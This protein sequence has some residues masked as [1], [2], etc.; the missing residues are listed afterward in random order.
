MIR[1]LLLGMA[2]IEGAT[3]WHRLNAR[4]DQYAKAMD[5]ARA[6]GRPLVV[7]GV[8]TRLTPAHGYGDVC[9][10][11]VRGDECLI[12][13]R[14]DLTKGPIASIASDSVVVFCACVLEYV[15]DPYAVWAELVRMAGNADRIYLVTVEPWTLTGVLFPGTRWIITRDGPTIHAEEVTDARKGIYAASLGAAVMSLW[16]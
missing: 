15:T 2:V 12:S 7:V 6:C 4:Q 11:L 9:V 5:R 10:D 1:E 8:P 13:V 16:G 14:A 3:A